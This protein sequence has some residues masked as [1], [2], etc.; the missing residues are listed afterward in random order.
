M[1]LKQRSHSESMAEEIREAVTACHGIDPEEIDANLEDRVDP[2]SLATLWP[3]LPRECFGVVS[4]AF[5][6]CRVTVTMNGDVE[7]SL[8]Q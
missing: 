2:D 3:G 8:H 5:Y 6:D 7:A 4:F 1:A